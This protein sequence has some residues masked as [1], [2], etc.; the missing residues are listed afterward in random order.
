MQNPIIFNTDLGAGQS[1][2]G[3]L[4]RRARVVPRGADLI[5]DPEL[6]GFG[7]GDVA[8][9]GDALQPGIDANQP[10]ETLRTLS[11]G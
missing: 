7:G 8:A 3:R 6:Q 5:D 2:G 1:H 11:A 10:G 9:C 4:Y